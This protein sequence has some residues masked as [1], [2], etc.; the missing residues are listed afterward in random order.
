MAC[1]V[2]PRIRNKRGEVVPS[3]LFIE[4]N[5]NYGYDKAMEIYKGI[6]SDSFIDSFGDWINLSEGLEINIDGEPTFDSVKS[7]YNLVTND[8]FGSLVGFTV[9]KTKGQRK[10]QEELTP[11]QKALS[12]IEAE[13][14]ELSRLDINNVNRTKIK[15]LTKVQDELNDQLTLIPLLAFAEDQIG[16]MIAKLA[17]LTTDDTKSYTYKELNDIIKRTRFFGSALS[18]EEFTTNNPDLVKRRDNLVGT[19]ANQEHKILKLIEAKMVDNAAQDFNPKLLD[20]IMNLLLKKINPSKETSGV[21]R[22]TLD[23]SKAVDAINKLA[24][25]YS[26]STENEINQELLNRT[27][28]ITKAYN[29]IV[30]A[31]RKPEDVYEMMYEKLTNKKGEVYYSGKYVNKYSFEYNR[32]LN[33]RKNAI[34]NK[35]KKARIE[36]LEAWTKDMILKPIDRTKYLQDETNQSLILTPTELLAWQS[37]HDPEIYKGYYDLFKSGDRS[38][39]TINTLLAFDQTIEADQYSYF[40][41]SP[42]E[43]LI[44]PQWKAIQADP[45]AKEFYDAY[46]EV[47]VK[48]SNDLPSRF[49]NGKLIPSNYIFE[50]NKS[51][52]EEMASEPLYRVLTTKARLGF[53]NTITEDDN[54][55]NYVYKNPY[56]GESEY[57]LFVRNQRNLPLD[58][59]SKNLYNIAITKAALALEFKN[60]K[61]LEPLLLLFRELSKTKPV[62]NTKGELILKPDNNNIK[63]LD[64]RLNKVLYGKG[65]VTEGGKLNAKIY[66]DEDLAI[67]KE[68][69]KQIKEK[70]EAKTKAI[71][72]NKSQ[73][74]IN[75]ID[76]EIAELNDSLFKLGNMISYRQVV[77]TI[78]DYTRIKGLAL[79]GV[80]AITDVIFGFVSLSTEGTRYGINPL[81]AASSYRLAQQSLVTRTISGEDKI[82]R[83]AKLFDVESKLNEYKFNSKVAGQKNVIDKVVNSDNFFILQTIS[84]KINAYATMIGV[85]KTTKVPGTTTNI[86]DAFDKEGNWKLDIPNPYEVTYDEAGNFIPNKEVTKMSLLINDTTASIHGNYDTKKPIEGKKEWYGRAAFVFKSWLPNSVQNRIG[87]Q[88]IDLN[89]GREMKGRYRSIFNKGGFFRREDGKFVFNRLTKNA[90]SLIGYGTSEMNELDTQNMR[91]NLY[92]MIAASFMLLLALVL[93]NL[94]GDDDDDESNMLTYLVNQNNRIMKDLSFYYNPW[95]FKQ[96]LDINT[97]IPAMMTIEDFSKLFV[98]TGRT[99]FDSKYNPTINRG[100][101]KGKNRLVTEGT[102]MIPGWF[103]VKR[104]VNFVTAPKEKHKKKVSK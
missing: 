54:Q 97:L 76:K 7:H 70:E 79:N 68:L 80:S 39:E 14:T 27:E 1:E 41:F 78:S 55:E 71:E 26:L 86:Y 72:Q 88:Q 23:S 94:S 66:K 53:L 45:L 17:L 91:V 43:N 69:E 65:N 10:A 12:K 64:F 38:N 103:G 85:L 62:L 81:V 95:G 6:H 40:S 44:D 82:K 22:F 83:F 18:P 37:V 75:K 102:D 5:T 99:L 90:L 100:A 67:A 32:L 57:G 61:E 56:T 59:K 52:Y 93:K 89:S 35:S 13:L 8:S 63:M 42:S 15:E 60:K 50:L 87:R 28:R 46:K 20:G 24:D 34:K 47:D 3:K 92:E 29:A 31:G 48:S 9:G 21:E 77:D 84:G 98:I 19:I 51:L 96:M 58:Y 101:D 104:T 74:F 25:H 33:I 4:L 73:A 2:T 36:Y 30:K 16:P 49:I 11:V